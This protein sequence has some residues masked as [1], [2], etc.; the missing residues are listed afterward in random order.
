MSFTAASEGEESPK[1]TTSTI[2]VAVRPAAQ[3]SAVTE[4]STFGFVMLA[5]PEATMGTAGIL[6]SMPLPTD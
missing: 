2:A 6:M 1:S 5:M 3:A 4:L